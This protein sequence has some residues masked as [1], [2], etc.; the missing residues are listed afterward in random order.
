M[1]TIYPINPTTT[2][3][4]V[5][6]RSPIYQVPEALNP[7]FQAPLQDQILNINEGSTYTLPRVNVSNKDS[8]QIKVKLG[9]AALFTAYSNGKFTFNPMLE[10][11]FLVTVKI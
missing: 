2:K 11:T 7:S 4:P 8:Y 5:V 9:E 10:G 6:T 1:N 3:A